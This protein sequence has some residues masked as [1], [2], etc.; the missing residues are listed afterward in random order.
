MIEITIAVGLIAVACFFAAVKFLRW[1][2]NSRRIARRLH[3]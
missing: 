2:E 1:R 3:F